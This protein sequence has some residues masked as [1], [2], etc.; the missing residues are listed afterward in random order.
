MAFFEEQFIE[1]IKEQR[2]INNRRKRS[3]ELE[4]EARE[5]N[6]SLD[7]IESNYSCNN[8]SFLVDERREA[9]I[10]SDLIESN[11]SCNNESFVVDE[12]SYELQYYNYNN[13]TDEPYNFDDMNVDNNYY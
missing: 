3:K 12:K 2:V 5:A 13:D 10:S 7:L 9:N 6:I 11:Y 8:E 1:Q 4:R